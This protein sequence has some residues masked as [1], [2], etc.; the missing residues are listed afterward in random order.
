MASHVQFCTAK[1]I[2]ATLSASYDVFFREGLP[3]VPRNVDKCFGY[4]CVVLVILN[5][6]P[7][8]YNNIKLR[9]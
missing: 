1:E 3:G 8:L 9:I 6:L 2:I 4:L 5:G 7:H